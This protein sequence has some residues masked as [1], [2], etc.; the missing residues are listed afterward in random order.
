M[1]VADCEVAE[2]FNAIIGTNGWNAWAKWNQKTIYPECTVSDLH[3]EYLSHLRSSW[4]K[5]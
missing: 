2:I 1:H 3:D 4:A 5:H